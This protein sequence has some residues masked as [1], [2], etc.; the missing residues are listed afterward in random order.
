MSLCGIHLKKLLYQAASLGQCYPV[1]YCRFLS[2]GLTVASVWPQNTSVFTRNGPLLSGARLYGTTDDNTAS[3]K[4]IR[5]KKEHPNARDVIA[6]VGHMIPYN[7]VEVISE[8]GENLGKMN[9][10]DVLKIMKENNLKLV[11]FKEKADPPVYRLL[12]GKQ[13]FEERTKL[14]EE[15]KLSPQSG[16]VQTKEVSVLSAISQHDLQIKL[17]QLSQWIEKKHH[18]RVSVLKSR[19]AGSPKKE[20]LLQQLLNSVADYATYLSIPRERKDGRA[21]VCVLRP[22][23]AKELQKQKKNTQKEPTAAQETNVE[24]N[25]DTA[26]TNP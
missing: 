19:T 13:L 5:K 24:E 8:N 9:R 3:T 4:P 10:R 18:V 14:R 11:C 12:T 16:P 2:Q 7:I 20:D 6:H 15:K 25:P 22:L 21:I 23:S 17:K 1:R 26:P